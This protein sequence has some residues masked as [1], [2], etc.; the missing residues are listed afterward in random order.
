MSG[1][2][3]A[4]FVVAAT[5]VLAGP[6]RAQFCGPAADPCVVNANTVV[7]GGTV[8]DLK[9]R[10][11]V[12]ASG[13]TITVQGTGNGSFTLTAGDVTFRD[14]ARLIAGGVNGT[15]GNVSIKA[16][17]A[18]VMQ[19]NSRIEVTGGAAGSVT[20]VAASAK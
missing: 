2:R 12:V 5:T 7:P 13:V 20:M 11:F 19:A 6:A 3:A 9:T 15:G 8:V 1:T 14:G 10:A 16:S 18:V 17:G 4:F